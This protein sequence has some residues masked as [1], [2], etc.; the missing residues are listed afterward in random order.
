VR[1]GEVSLENFPCCCGIEGGLELFSASALLA[2]AGLCG[3]RG[4]PLVDQ[5]RGEMKAPSE[6]LRKAPR[7]A[8]QFVF[9]PVGVGRNADDKF[10]RLPFPYQSRNRRKPGAI[11][12][13]ANDGE[14]MRNAYREVADR[15]ANAF[16]AEVERQNRSGPRVSGER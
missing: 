3:M 15:N 2:Q 13:A 7:E 12:L 11:V 5:P 14:G 16:F 1:G 8:S 6:S 10:D 9:R 4:E